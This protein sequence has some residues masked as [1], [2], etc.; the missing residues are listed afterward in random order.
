MND[1]STSTGGH[2]VK[3]LRQYG[4]TI[5]ICQ[6]INNTK[7]SSKTAVDF[8]LL[9]QMHHER[10]I[11]WSLCLQEGRSK[12]RDTRYTS[13]LKKMHPSKALVL[14]LHKAKQKCNLFS[15]YQD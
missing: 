7:V 6:P 10:K 13:K 15:I 12:R 1:I 14:I 11:S 9:G 8:V 2:R 3:N 4:C 5:S